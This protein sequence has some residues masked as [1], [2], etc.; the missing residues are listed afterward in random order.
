MVLW[1]AVC[2]RTY[3]AHS[4]WLAFGPAQAGRSGFAHIGTFTWFFSWLEV[5]SSKSRDEPQNLEMCVMTLTPLLLWKF[6]KKEHFWNT[7]HCSLVSLQTHKYNQ[8]IMFS[9]L[10]YRRCKY[11]HFIVVSSVQFI[12]FLLCRHYFIRLRAKPWK[13]RK[14]NKLANHKVH[15][16]AIN[17]SY[18]LSDTQKNALSYQFVKVFFLVELQ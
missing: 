17:Q 8:K 1:A 9:S 12:R 7:V 6:D 11:V 16:F 15:K 4:A 14:V 18:L 3:P 10:L 13:P 5:L 2:A